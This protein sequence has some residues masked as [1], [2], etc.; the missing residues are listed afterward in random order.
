MFG[1]PISQSLSAVSDRIVLCSEAV[2]VLLSTVRLI[3]NQD[4]RE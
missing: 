4:H 3:L 1:V 2:S